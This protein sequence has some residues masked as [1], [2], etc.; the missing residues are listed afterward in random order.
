MCCGHVNRGQFMD[1]STGPMAVMSLP[2]ISAV[3]GA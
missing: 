2:P 3:L 1:I